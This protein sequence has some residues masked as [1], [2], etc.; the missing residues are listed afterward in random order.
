VRHCHALLALLLFGFLRLCSSQALLHDQQQ[1]IMLG[2][3]ITEG[4]DPDGYVNLTRVMLEQLYPEKNIY[5]ANAGKGGDTC[6]DMLERLE[7]D[8]LR[9]KPDWVTVSV[10]VNDVGKT[11]AGL[12]L[13]PGETGLPA[14]IFQT[15]VEEII[16]RLK[17][18]GSQVALFTTTVV[19]EDLSSAENIKLVFY[20]DVLR[21]LAQRHQCVL[22]DMD[23][24]FRRVLSPI[25]KPGMALSGVLT[26]DGAHMLARGNWLMAETLLKAFGATRRQ[27]DAVKPTVLSRIARQKAA[28]AENLAH[29]E[30]E[31][32]ALRTAAPLK[33]RLVFIGSSLVA[34]WK[35]TALFPDYQ[36]INRGLETET[37]RQLRMRFHQD[38]VALKPDVVF[39]FADYLDDLTKMSVTDILSHLA[40]IARLAKGS[41]I[42]VALGS[43][44][45]PR[46]AGGDQTAVCA[47]KIAAL[48][49]QIN[50]LCTENGY[51]YIDCLSPLAD[52]QGFRN[53]TLF[54]NGRQLNA[55]GYAALQPLIESTL[56][57]LRWQTCTLRPNGTIPLWTVAGRFPNIDVYHHTPACFG[58]FTDWLAPSGGETNVV[59]REGDKVSYE[60]GKQVEWKTTCS[61]STGLLDYLRILSIDHQTA[62]VCYAYCRLRSDLEQKAVL[63]IQSNDGVRVWL[64]AV[65]VHDHHVGRT[66][67]SE[68]DRVIVDLRRGENPLL[69][70]VDQSG[71]GWALRLRVTDEKNLPIQ[72]VTEAVR[73]PLSDQRVAAAKKGDLMAFNRSDEPTPSTGISRRFE[74]FIND[75]RCT[76]EQKDYAVTAGQPNMLTIKPI[77]TKQGRYLAELTRIL[78]NGRSDRQRAMLV[79]AAAAAMD[80]GLFAVPAV[81]DYRAGVVYRQGC[82]FKITIRE[83]DSN[84]L[85][86]EQRFL[87]TISADNLHEVLQFGDD[88]EKVHLG[89]ESF[90]VHHPMDPPVLMWLEKK[91]LE[92]QDSVVI[93][94]Q[95]AAGHAAQ[96]PGLL[97]VENL[98]EPQSLLNK[99]ITATARPQRL[100]LKAAR[101]KQGEYRITFAPQVV[102][103][104]DHE[105]PSLIYRRQKK[106]G[107]IRISP[108]APWALDRD[109][110]RPELV[111]KDFA[112]AVRQ[113]SEGLPKNSRWHLQPDS[114][115]TC[116]INPS[117]DW[118]EPPVVLRPGLQGW[119]AMFARTVRGYAYV[120]AGKNG[121]PRG[122]GSESSF[123]TAM[124][125][126]DEEMAIYAAAVPG[127]GLREL[128]F[129]PIMKASAEKLLTTLSQPAIPLIGVVDWGD[130]F[131]PPPIFHSAGGRPAQDQFDALLRGHAE[132]GIRSINWALGR[133]CLLY[134]SELPNAS[135]FPSVPPERMVDQSARAD[136][137]VQAWII[138]R[139][140]Q[141][142]YVLEQRERAGIKI[143]PW[144]T[145][146]RHYGEFYDEGI[147]AS[148]WFKAHPE[149]RRWRKNASGPCQ[150]EVS[151]FFPEV[152]KERVDIFCEV[153]AKNPDGLLIGAC[154]QP[155]M[156]GYEPDLVS[157]YEKL[158]GLQARDIDAAAQMAEYE[159]WIRWR[160]D[161]F[162]QTLRELHDRL[163]PIRR[164]S[165]SPI[166]VSIRVP[167]KGFFVNRAQGLDVETWCR[168]KLVARLQLDPLED[169]QGAGSHDITLYVELAERHGIEVYGGINGNTWWNVQVIYRRALG[170]LQAG[171]D[172]IE[173][174]ESN[175]YAVLRPERWIVP[176]LN[177]GE[178]ISRFLQTSNLDACFP[179]WSRNAA[180]GH[181]NHSFRDSWSVYDN[182]GWGL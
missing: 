129:V 172:G 102:G 107:Q 152:R 65:R 38:A 121:V 106:D 57:R 173:L 124:N 105:G 108:Y 170:L 89:W 83:L 109:R 111:V 91:I 148:K 146:N 141:L 2:D 6:I 50:K 169:S 52:D 142:S 163:E 168:E 58:Y 79:P 76:Q 49:G 59:P 171:V 174:Y 21:G 27:L 179:I 127:S 40:R 12:P 137:E 167:C 138:A 61:D 77:E 56:H 153:A 80:L 130:Y 41:A 85:V 158:T 39:I 117:G 25:Q 17:A 104:N 18:Q 98:N 87:Q 160:A 46:R 51:L 53:E 119:Y 68:E 14:A 4:E 31:N 150:G 128:R 84:T 136:L 48:N 157:A 7:R 164:K 125:L 115:G 135:L 155:P 70:K 166:P 180:A 28:L 182:Q 100:K 156:L 93:C 75:Q 144:L 126:T 23:R 110:A 13:L 81:F 177:R 88:H 154:R 19:K 54:A 16:L 112:R 120:R 43:S 3:S 133:S 37:I 99:R 140:D 149:W 78:P 10:G 15:K 63:H 132:L 151:Y 33:N 116:L 94:Y 47:E 97:K 11:P 113:W 114:S 165:G 9:F 147:G 45:P 95:L 42:A 73:G 161:F 30:C 5:V 32:G 96:L 103:C 82:R 118:Q 178:G 62:G 159:K 134:H 181:D 74:F 55:R 26:S 8:V 29:Y 22:V 35:V 90:T 175:N 176:M 20:N 92:N 123:I 101:W 71:G 139:Q 131:C 34:R 60:S 67:D 69:V 86:E 44:V 143:I 72:Q 145:M 122:I 66:V 24:A 1:I 64:N 162:T 36:A